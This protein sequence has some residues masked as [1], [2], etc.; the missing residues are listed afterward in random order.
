MSGGQTDGV[1]TYATEPNQCTDSFKPIFSFNELL[2]YGRVRGY[3]SKGSRGWIQ[4]SLIRNEK[5][6]NIQCFSCFQ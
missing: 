6:L 3:F 1:A 4:L 2:Y 5:C